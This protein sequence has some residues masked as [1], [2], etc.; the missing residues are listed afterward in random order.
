MITYEEFEVEVTPGEGDL[1]DVS[2]RSSE[3]DGKHHMVLP[4]TLADLV[5]VVHGVHPYIPPPPEGAPAPTEP[6][7]APAGKADELGSA[8]FNAL[9]AGETRDMLRSTLSTA[10]KTP[11]RGVRVRLRM[12]MRDDRICEVAALPWEMMCR[13]DGRSLFATDLTTLV[14]AVDT[15]EPTEPRP[16][17]GEPLR[18]LALKSNPEGTAKLNLQTEIDAVEI[19][20]AKLPGVE[21][22]FV[23]PTQS[24]IWEAMNS[25]AYDV[26]HY[27]GHGGF[28]PGS[29]GGR[30]LLEND[31]GSLCRVPARD[32]AQWLSRRRPMLVFLNACETGRPPGR[33]EVPPFAGV[34]VALVRS[35]IPAVIGNQFSVSDAAAIRFADNFYKRIVAG[36]PVDAAAATARASLYQSTPPIQWATPVLYMRSKTGDLFG[37]APA[38]TPNAAPATASPSS[39][40]EPA[41]AMSNTTINVG[42]DATGNVFATGDNST[43]NATVTN[44][45]TTGTLPPAESVDMPAVMQELRDFIAG[46]QLDKREEVQ[47]RNALEEVEME[48]Q[49]SEPNKEA[50]SG[51]VGR[52]LT[53]LR[54]ANKFTEDV[55]AAAPTLIKLGGWLGATFSRPLLGSIGIKV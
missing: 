8:L 34:A 41:R 46:L 19:S 24:A 1:F 45:V 38:A 44:T 20:W 27:M 9:F 51:A 43:T 10:A 5:G 25:K 35:G 7:P 23:A 14:R 6:P 31:D 55:Q 11:D 33:A 36:D 2:V 39:Q 32:F 40:P 22:D 12:D 42:R 37:R 48:V 52:I 30:L 17:N 4:F 26:V 29:T 54:K 21:V 13:D 3:G 49:A 53:A 50:A 16:L 15:D 18:I 47:V 28:D